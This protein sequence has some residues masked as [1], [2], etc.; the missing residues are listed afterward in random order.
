MRVTA[1]AELPGDVVLGELLLWVLEHLLEVAVDDDLF[2]PCHLLVARRI[3]EISNAFIPDQASIRRVPFGSQSCREERVTLPR[4]TLLHWSQDGS[5]R[6]STNLSHTWTQEGE[7]KRALAHVEWVA[8]A[9]T[10][11]RRRRFESRALVLSGSKPWTRFANTCRR[12]QPASRGEPVT[13]RHRRLN[14]S[15]PTYDSALVLVSFESMPMLTISTASP[16][17]SP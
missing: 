9:V 10:S 14:T 11:E 7:L 16:G 15:S 8:P 4:G 2:L 12:Q 17:S 5:P 13:P 6:I 3:V 1:S